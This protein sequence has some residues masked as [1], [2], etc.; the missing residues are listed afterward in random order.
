M[1][2]MALLRISQIDHTLPTFPEIVKLKAGSHA[3]S[4]NVT[5]KK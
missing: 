2:N 4:K 1:K 3:I 5:A